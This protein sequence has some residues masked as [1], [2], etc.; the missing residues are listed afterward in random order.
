MSAAIFNFRQI[1][2]VQQNGL[3]YQDHNGNEV[4]I[5][6]EECY[7]NYLKQLLSPESVESYKVLNH[8]TDDDIEAYIAR[9]QSWREIGQRNIL[10]ES[11]KVGRDLERGLPYIEF[12]TSPLVRFEFDNEDDYG[13]FRQKIEGDFHWRTSDLT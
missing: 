12:Y 11:K 9:V 7:Q 4:F 5:E 1:K 13:T 6:F 8:K 3:I 10:G 2:T